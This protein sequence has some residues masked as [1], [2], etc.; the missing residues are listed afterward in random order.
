MKTIRLRAKGKA[1]EPP[2]ELEVGAIVRLDAGLKPGRNRT[3]KRGGEGKG[4]EE[5]GGG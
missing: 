4:L 3:K 2:A 5:G 1:A